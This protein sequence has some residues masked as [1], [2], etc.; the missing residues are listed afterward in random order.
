MIKNLE[1]F[2]SAVRRELPPHAYHPNPSIS[3]TA[4]RKCYVAYPKKDY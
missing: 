2:T 1:H 4:M 3:K